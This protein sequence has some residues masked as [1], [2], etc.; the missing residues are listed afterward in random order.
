MSE[1][2]SGPA[3]ARQGRGLTRSSWLGMGTAVFAL[4]TDTPLKRHR[5]GQKVKAPRPV[6]VGRGSRCGWSGPL[7]AH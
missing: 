3:I 1:P 7:K 4:E 5:E 2:G 6:G